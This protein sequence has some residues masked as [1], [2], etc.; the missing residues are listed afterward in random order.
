M[1]RGQVPEIL[2]T[3][4]A[5]LTTTL[6]GTMFYLASF[7]VVLT[8]V[9]FVHEL[10]HF[11]VARWCGVKV[12][13]F[14]IGFGKE[15][16]GFYDRHGTRWRF[17]WIPLG[18]YV[19]FMDDANGASVPDQDAITEMTEEEKAGSFHH[20]PL[21]RRAAV[22]A[23]GPFANFIFAI[24]VFALLFTFVG[25]RT[26]TARVDEVVA[27]MPA[28]AAGFKKG[29]IIREIG[30]RD[31]KSFGDVL[32]LISSS[33]S[34][35]VPVTV[36]RD[37]Q[38]VNLTVTPKATEVNDRIGGKITR[39]VIGIRHAPGPDGYTHNR[40]GPLESVWLG[41]KETEFII[42]STL[43]YLGDVVTG[44]QKPDQLG[45]V[46]RIADVSG[47]VA[48]VGPEAFIHLIAVLSISVGLINLFPIPLLD[49]G[50]LLF[51]AIEAVRGRPLSETTQ[52]YGF[53]IGFALVISLMV[54]ATWNDRGV[55]ARWL[56][57]ETQQ[58]QSQ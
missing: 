51:Y 12:T 45:G 19:K 48:Q 58:N 6:S 50:H 20:K 34:R 41:V 17:A 42:T 5:S 2:M 4:L 11:L 26:T 38:R 30:G 57:I 1:E 43:S 35:E 24:F 27:G 55:V 56:D 53:K 32:R 47:K 37:G 40:S 3:I 28:E 13:T 54:F 9:V 52:E 36:E 46:I 21:W 25:Q 33:P 49:G 7:L 29:D 18:G 31:V 44:Y 22:V 39:G 10:G 15:I 8:I 23:A 14:S 16:F